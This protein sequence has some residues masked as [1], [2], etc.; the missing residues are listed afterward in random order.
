MP[1]VRIIGGFIT[2]NDMR[3][4]KISSPLLHSLESK[5]ELIEI[6]STSR[7][8]GKEVI[9]DLQEDDLIYYEFEDGS[10]LWMS[11]EEVM[12]ITLAKMSSDFGRDVKPSENQIWILPTGINDLSADR[13]IDV[14]YAVKYICKIGDK[15]LKFIADPSVENGVRLAAELFDEL[16]VTQE[17]L[18]AINGLNA[19]NYDIK[20]VNT[21]KPVLLFIHGTVSNTI[22]AFSDFMNEETN[23]YWKKIKQKYQ[24]NILS[25]NHRTL[26]K[27]PFENVFNLVENLPSD[28][29]LHAIAHS[30]GGIVLETLILCN[31]CIT[32]NNLI[33]DIRSFLQNNQRPAEADFFEKIFAILK[34]KNIRIKKY[35]KVASPSFGT[36]LLSD[37]PVNYFRK[38]FSIIKNNGEGNFIRK[39][40]ELIITTLKFKDDIRVLPGLEAMTPNSPILKLINKTDITSKIT[41]VVIAG[42]SDY[43][44]HTSQAF[45][46]IEQHFIRDERSDFIVNTSSMHQG[47]KL[48]NGYNYHLVADRFI[49]HFTYFRNEIALCV[50]H[51]T[52]VNDGE[53]IAH[54]EFLEQYQIPS[55]RGLLGIEY[56]RIKPENISGNRPVVLLVPGIL[57]STLSIEDKTYWIN[58]GRF[59]T[60]QLKE[61]NIKNKK[62]I[63]DG[64][65]K[66]AYKNITEYLKKEGYDVVI[67]PYDWRKSLSA[68]VDDFKQIVL[69]TIEKSNHHPIKII[70][71]SMGG[72]LVRSLSIH[73]PETYLKLSKIPEFRWV[74]LGT[75]WYGS[76]EAVQTLVGRSKRI[77]QIDQ[78]AF[79]DTM[80][81][82]LVMFSKYP[83]LLELLPL[84][85]KNG[86]LDKDIT[87]QSFWNDLHQADQKFSS[88]WVIPDLSD[89]TQL[90]AFKQS[91][92]N[93]SIPNPE[94]VYYIAGK[95]KDNRT[96][97]NYSIIDQSI[98][99]EFTPEGDGTVTWKEG[100]PSQ[101][102]DINH[103][104][105]VNASHGQLAN[106]KKFFPGILSIL[107]TGTTYLSKDPETLSRNTLHNPYT[108]IYRSPIEFTNNAEELEN[109]LFDADPIDYE[110]STLDKINVCISNGDLK[111]AD[112]P[113]MVGHF[114]GEY[115]AKAEGDLND[116]FG[117][118]L[119]K[120]FENKVYPGSIGTSLFIMRDKKNRPNGALIL[121]LGE[122][123]E[124]TGFT[125]STAVKEG[126]IDA[127]HQFHEN[128]S[129]DGEAFPSK[130]SSLLMGTAYGNLSV[131]TSLKSIITGVEMAN[132][133]LAAKQ[134]E[135]YYENII[136]SIE[137]IEIFA[138]KAYTTYYILSKFHEEGFTRFDPDTITIKQ[139]A[140]KNLSIDYSSDK[141]DQLTIRST[142]L[143]EG[144]SPHPAHYKK[145]AFSLNNGIAKEENREVTINKTQINTLLTKLIKENESEKN[146]D[147]AISKVLFER[148]IP[149]ELKTTIRMQKNLVINLDS[150]AAAY[151]WELIQDTNVNDKPICV[152]AGMIRQLN[153]KTCLSKKIYGEENR[154]LIIGDPQLEPNTYP[155][156]SGAVL[157][158]N[159]VTEIFVG[160]EFQTTSIVK[161]SEIDIMMSLYEQTYKYIHIA[162]HG[163]FDPTESL[164]SGVLIGAKIENG[165]IVKS[166]LT[167]ADIIQLDVMPEFVFINTCYSG[168]TNAVDASFT[169]NP[170][171]FASNIGEEFI[172]NGVKAIIVAGWP[173]YDDMALLFADRFYENMFSGST[174]GEAV[175]NARQACFSAEPNKNTWGAYQ[176]YGDPMFRFKTK[177]ASKPKVFKLPQEAAFELD[178]IITQTDIPQLKYNKLIS[179]LQN[180]E[181]NMLRFNLTNGQLLEKLAFANYSLGNDDEA[182]K[183]L[184]SLLELDGASFSIRSYEHM[185]DIQSRKAVKE[186]DI[187]ALQKITDKLK[188][189][190]QELGESSSRALLLLN[191]MQ[192]MAYATK[193]VKA[194]QSIQIPSL[195]QPKPSNKY[196]LVELVSIQS[197]ALLS[198][199]KT[200]KDLEIHLKS[201]YKELKINTQ[202]N[203][204]QEKALWLQFYITQLIV[205][206]KVTDK[207]GKHISTSKIGKFLIGEFQEVWD[208]KGSL[209]Y[210]KNQ[211]ESLEITLH[212]LP[213]DHLAKPILKELVDY[214]QEIEEKMM[215]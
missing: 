168:K 130:I 174:F 103:V 173:V 210:V 117:G 123:F 54:T 106:D 182:L 116:A 193:D 17:G 144:N 209:R 53:K 95:S 202:S 18:M 31:E 147:Q 196:N 68:T 76:Y 198:Q 9:I 43:N 50:I 72:L 32:N 74:M 128:P 2:D 136:K 134:D 88:N 40:E 188:I 35:I 69:N 175:L 100:I 98:E 44:L 122:Q 89:L 79:F 135:P 120:R 125:L 191:F 77:Q 64:I 138:D 51:D 34:E 105:Y 4:L 190:I 211:I 131:E 60:N 61:L 213:E 194:F 94:S 52:L 30:R 25:F 115:I 6:G 111:Y 22:A 45:K 5:I 179:K 177:N 164:N 63:P 195:K 142:K 197:A 26:S 112:G 201:I 203:G 75:P 36:T 97:E 85:I 109:S 148:L 145:F 81:E 114:K 157:E 80:Y 187:D 108:Q 167:A 156:L 110:N 41:E 155:Q 3:E 28:I 160:N 121:G 205:T 208:I 204:F 107:N 78:I 62:I 212:F 27:G 57:G 171:E 67:C 55:E 16:R 7:L 172:A 8:D 49:D 165:E 21:E 200:L 150:E 47:L 23:P 83:G 127:F 86:I 186:K 99:F 158:A 199:G 15:A 87:N 29:E 33:S 132:K 82:L 101:L 153:Q 1:K 20:L 38:M 39:F 113:I 154:V 161:G 46:F 189:L 151:P 184:N 146:W 24:N 159:S 48:S 143:W 206:K 215:R 183:K 65:V 102:K 10:T 139:G 13:S 140:L 133:T 91:V 118:M 152:T 14:K 169:Y 37:H 207:D 170:Y 19:Y 185:L 93:Y 66:T 73:Y 104:Y 71:H 181:E 163:D 192:R 58:Y 59:M 124:T 56:G 90:S 126:I 129:N 141:W 84:N 70:S 162:A 92:E 119:M 214:C 11:Y 166:F 176:C 96:P 137:F 42:K 149:Q 180:V 12:K 178:N